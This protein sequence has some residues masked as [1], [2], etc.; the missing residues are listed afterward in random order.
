[1]KP[2]SLVASL[3]FSLVALAHLLRLVFQTDVLVGGTVMPMWLS[4]VG[5]LVTGGLAVGLWREG[6]ATR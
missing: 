2:A 5:L 4:V 3:V 1:M 6:R